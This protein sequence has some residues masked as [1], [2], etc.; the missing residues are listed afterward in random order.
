MVPVCRG[1]SGGTT[2]S[3]PRE[4]DS[5]SGKKKGVRLTPT[6]SPEGEQ[7]GF[8]VRP[9]V[10]WKTAEGLIEKKGKEIAPE[11]ERPAILS[12]EGGRTSLAGS[13][14]IIQEGDA[15]K[16]HILGVTRKNYIKR[17]GGL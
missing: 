10:Y 7:A 2:G 6:L 16:P 12:Y 4:R 3:G 1:L 8:V 14:S 9:I 5:M 17:G 13:T 15:A 11:R